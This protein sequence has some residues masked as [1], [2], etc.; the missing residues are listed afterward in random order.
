MFDYGLRPYKL[1][2]II[3]RLYRLV[4]FFHKRFI[5]LPFHI[6]LNT[7]VLWYRI[8]LV[9]GQRQIM[10]RRRTGIR[11]SALIVV[12]QLPEIPGAFQS[13]LEIDFMTFLRSRIHGCICRREPSVQKIIRFAG[14]C[15]TRITSHHRSLRI[16]YLYLKCLH[17]LLPCTNHRIFSAR[18]NENYE[19][20][21]EK[22]PDDYES[23]NGS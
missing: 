12:C 8:R 21:C 5:P 22:D 19:K 2:N 6:R 14:L 11:I 18:L 15:Q 16:L 4:I 20:E 7:S 13:P 9:K 3:S 23:Q 10:E 1:V 17:H